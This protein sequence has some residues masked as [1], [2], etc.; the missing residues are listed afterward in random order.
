MGG[1]TAFTAY[2]N[3]SLRWQQL[4]S[5]ALEIQS[6]IWTFRCRAG[7][8]RSSGSGGQYNRSDEL[9]FH[10]HLQ[11]VINRILEGTD[12]KKTAFYGKAREQYAKHG[13][14]NMD[15]SRK[16]RPTGDNHH[17]PLQPA[18]YIALRLRQER[19]F[20]RRRLP[21]YGTK[22]S[23]SQAVL[24]GGSLAQ[25]V[26]AFFDMTLWAGLVSA[27]GAAVTAWMA[28]TSTAEKMERYSNTMNALDNLE[29]WWDALPQV[30]QQSVSNIDYLIGTCEQIIQMER[31]SWYA[32]TID[33][34][35]ANGG[36]MGVGADGVGAAGAE[37]RSILPWNS[38]RNY[39][40]SPTEQY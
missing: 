9:I 8:Y 19:A 37:R 3:P 4:R 20:Y 23:V 27:V 13:Q 16:S 5:A 33:V 35:Q 32:T 31:L 12:L 18:E 6:E 40:V 38:E 39:R 28:F 34:K 30:E 26:L 17:S 25:S 1:T 2:Q 29:M 24:I 36:E 15:E 22:H 14:H 7:K 10:A 11:S 21:V